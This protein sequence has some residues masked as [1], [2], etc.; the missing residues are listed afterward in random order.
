MTDGDS[1]E[2]ACVRGHIVELFPP[3]DPH[4]SIH[5]TGI[6]TL[7][8]RDTVLF[9][10]C[11]IHTLHRQDEIKAQEASR[12]SNRV[13]QRKTADGAV[14]YAMKGGLLQGRRH[15]S[16]HHLSEIPA[17]IWHS[18][19]IWEPHQFLLGDFLCDN[20][21]TIYGKLQRLR[22]AKQTGR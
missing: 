17:R 4:R 21:M 14:S 2:C 3:S 6:L 9:V 8:F 18:T 7:Q 15:R 22:N 13:S 11:L 12:R 5:T 1:E 19:C 10:C 16:H 20:F